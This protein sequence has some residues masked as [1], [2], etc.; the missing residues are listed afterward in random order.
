MSNPVIAAQKSNLYSNYW[1]TA[2][3]ATPAE[4]NTYVNT[5]EVW[6]ARRGDLEAGFEPFLE[7]KFKSVEAAQAY[8][9]SW[10]DLSDN[11]EFWVG[12]SAL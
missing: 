4:M 12:K 8:A 11:V 2:P 9:D 5:V 6:S 7:G 3:S 10:N 1:N